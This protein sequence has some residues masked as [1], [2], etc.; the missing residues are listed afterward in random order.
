MQN[1]VEN[2]LRNIQS[3]RIVAVIVR[4]NLLNVCNVHTSHRVIYLAGDYIFVR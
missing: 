4:A 2:F 1:V 3:M